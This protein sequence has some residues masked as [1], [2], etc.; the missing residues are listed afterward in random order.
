MLINV[1]MQWSKETLHPEILTKI[2]N[3]KD[4]DEDLYL[5]DLY[6]LDFIQLSNVLFQQKRDIEI[7]ELTKLLS[8]TDFN[9]EDQES[10]KKYIPKS[11]WE[12]YFD[13]I[14]DVKSKD[15]EDKWKRLYKLRNKVAHNRFIDKETYSEIKGLCKATKT[16]LTSAINKLGEINLDEEDIEL[17]MHSY[18]SEFPQSQALLA[19][20]AVALYYSNNAYTV[21]V[22]TTNNFRYEADFIAF[23]NDTSIAIEV[24]YISFKSMVSILRKTIIRV[25]EVIEFNNYSKGEIVIVL[26]DYSDNINLIKI[27]EILYSFE[28]ENELGNIKVILGF[29]NEKKEFELINTK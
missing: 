5:N 20:K 6:K 25:K 11:N 4:E 22:P 19:E 14:L 9:D 28:Q 16:I 27:Q 3:Y 12:K 8:K 18:Q 13:E 26:R 24:K 1:G 15:L 10:I 7:G 17:I 29:L 21:K 23:L 2:K